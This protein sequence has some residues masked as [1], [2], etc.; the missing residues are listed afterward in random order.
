VDENA[1]KYP[2]QILTPDHTLK[3]DVPPF[4]VLTGKP[5]LV[6]YSQKNFGPRVGIAYRLPHDLVLRSG[7]AIFYEFNQSL[8]QS[9]NGNTGQWPF[10][11]PDFTPS[12]LNIP[13]AE[14]PLPTGVLGS[15]TLFPPLALSY[16]PPLGTA[17]AVESHT[18]Y[19]YV[20]QWNLGIQKEL[21]SNWAL[22]IDYLGT[23]GTHM[24]GRFAVN[25]AVP[26]VTPIETRRRIPEI[27]ILR[28]DPHWFNSSYN[29][30]T[31]K[32]EHRGR[33]LTTILGY[34]YSHSID[35]ISCTHGD[36]GK[37]QNFL[38]FRASRGNSDF[39]ITHNFVAS[40][41]Y[42]LPFGKGRRY[43]SGSGGLANGLLGGWQ[44]MGI[45]MLQTGMPFNIFI[46]Q[47]NANVGI[48][49]QR[50][51]VTSLDDLRL[52]SSEQT[53]NR[54]FNT[55]ALYVSPFGTFGNLGRNVL[56]RDGVVSI[57]LG[58]AKVF[59]IHERAN[60]EFRAEFFNLPNHANFGDPVNFLGR[61]NFGQVTSY[62]PGFTP[63]DIQFGLKVNF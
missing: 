48:T 22:S 26:G 3:Q 13:T 44:V 49:Q 60:I 54:W 5:G 63:R 39:D 38:D 10:G 46:S 45:T 30:A 47:D 9:Q 2:S 34:A 20:Q 52:S 12:G 35:E 19:P 4:E 58:L 11:F 40:W 32:L 59:P 16:Q 33:E 8:F 17:F 36:C 25:T 21:P 53:P 15:G 42:Q 28:I 27:G 43:L 41:V 61:G 29:A 55:N 23:K 31:V 7:Y 50:P 18:Q 57:D 6:D 1:L 37:T 56:R 62:A 24:G 14:N 51:S